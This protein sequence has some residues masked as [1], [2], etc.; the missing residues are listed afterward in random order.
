MYNLST[1]FFECNAPYIVVVFLFFLS[2]S[3]NS[4]SFHCSAPAPYLNTTTAYSFIVDFLLFLFD[5]DFSTNQSLRLYSFIVFSFISFSLILSNSNMFKYVEICISFFFDL[6]HYFTISE[7][8]F[9][10]SNYFPSLY[11]KN[12]RFFYS[13]L[14]HNISTKNMNSSHNC[15]YLFFTP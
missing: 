4:L 11:G 1:F 2:I 6:L 12:S 8:Y 7:L 15:I 14:H 5:F 9:L 3:F 13:K 10:R